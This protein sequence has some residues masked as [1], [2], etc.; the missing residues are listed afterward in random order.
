[1]NFEGSDGWVASWLL[2]SVIFCLVRLGVVN[3]MHELI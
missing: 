1:M 3:S 2:P